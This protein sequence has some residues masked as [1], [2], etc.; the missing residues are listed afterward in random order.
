[1]KKLLGLLVIA[2]SLAAQAQTN[3][4]SH[5]TDEIKAS[6]NADFSYFNNESGM[7]RVSKE[8]SLTLTPFEGMTTATTYGA[9]T[10]IEDGKYSISARVV[11]SKNSSLAKKDAPLLIIT[12]SLRETQKNNKVNVRAYNTSTSDDGPFASKATDL[13][14]A[15]SELRNTEVMTI[16]LE[17]GKGEPVTGLDL[18]KAGLVDSGTL[19][20]AGL[21]CSFFTGE[22]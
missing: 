4:G 17:H 20:S 3:I 18:L 6:C 12:A 15:R 11:V 10:V 8:V 22:Q 16:A 19:H 14:G 5:K 2:G 7:K 1:M 21:F 9:N 13:F